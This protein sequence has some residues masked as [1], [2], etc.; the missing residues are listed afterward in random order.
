MSSAFAPWSIAIAAPQLPT[1]LIESVQ[2]AVV[3]AGFGDAFPLRRLAFARIAHGD[4]TTAELACHL[5]VTK[6]AAAQLAQR[7]VDAG[8]IVRMPHPVRQRAGLLALTDRGVVCTEVARAATET[9]VGQ[10]RVEL[11]ADAAG[12]EVALRSLTSG[13]TALR[14]RP[15]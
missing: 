10:W 14:P 2:S 9:A 13:M 6:Q 8:C 3:E 7:L 15:V 1:R 11:G 12:F 4:G 5:R